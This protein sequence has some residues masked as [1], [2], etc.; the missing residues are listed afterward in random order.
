M[1]IGIAAVSQ[2][3]YE[4]AFNAFEHRGHGKLYLESSQ[5]IIARYRAYLRPGAA[6][7]WRAF[8]PGHFFETIGNSRAAADA[9]DRT[10][11]LHHNIRAAREHL[12]QTRDRFKG[13][14]I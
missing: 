8:P 1:V 12:K 6:S 5:C 3:N 13:K 2:N 4:V 11:N 7:L 9:W 14:L 10:L